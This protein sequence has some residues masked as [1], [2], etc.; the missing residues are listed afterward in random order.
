MFSPWAIGGG[1]RIHFI[2]HSHS[3]ESK[4]K[5][6]SEEIWDTE[7]EILEIESEYTMVLDY[8]SK[9]ESAEEINDIYHLS[10]IELHG[11]AFWMGVAFVS[12]IIVGILLRWM[13]N[14]PSMKRWRRSCCP[15]GEAPESGSTSAMET[16]ILELK[17]L[18]KKQQE[19]LVKP[20]AARVPVVSG[21]QASAPPA[22]GES[23]LNL[24]DKSSFKNLRKDVYNE[25]LEL[26]REELG[27][28]FA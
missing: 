10:F 15:C 3:T 27:E 18:V 16:Q 4:V 12:V 22:E 23:N 25:R 14:K 17:E 13:C 9:S 8:H 2:S 20:E 24:N 1:Q 28:E 6:D 5:V 11:G 26:I 19:I 21:E 7:Q